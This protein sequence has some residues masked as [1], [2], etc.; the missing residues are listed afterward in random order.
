LEQ[1]RDIAR[2]EGRSPELSRELIDWAWS[3]YFTHD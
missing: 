2:Y 3:N 1:L